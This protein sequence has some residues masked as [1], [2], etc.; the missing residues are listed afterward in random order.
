MSQ[1]FGNIDVDR[2][3]RIQI[4]TPPDFAEIRSLEM[5]SLYYCM[6][7]ATFGNHWGAADMQFWGMLL[8]ESLPR[9]RDWHFHSA[10]QLQNTCQHW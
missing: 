4:N 6:E 8:L 2:P 10:N 7:T 9:L 5:T 3:Y 1:S